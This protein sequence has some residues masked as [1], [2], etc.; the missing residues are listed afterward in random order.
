MN[1]REGLVPQNYV[2]IQTPRLVHWLRVVC[3]FIRKS[4]RSFQTPLASFIFSFSSEFGAYFGSDFPGLG[5]KVEVWV[6]GRGLSVEHLQ[7]VI[8]P[9]PNQITDIVFG[10]NELL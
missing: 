8:Q 1:G 10:V 9:P 2:Q 3:R 5:V 7:D 6:K 4:S